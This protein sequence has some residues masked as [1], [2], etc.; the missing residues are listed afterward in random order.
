MTNEVLKKA[1]DIK[2]KINEFDKLRLIASKPYKKFTLS[3]RERLFISDYDEFQMVICDKG[4]AE[5]IE[6]YCNK[7][8]KEL[9]EE[10]ERL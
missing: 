2:N 9:N 7:R 3:K 4:L 10:L 1:N 6:E 5:L 8:I